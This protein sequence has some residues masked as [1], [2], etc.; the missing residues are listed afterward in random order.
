[1][2]NAKFI[3]LFQ[4]ADR[5]AQST[6][7]VCGELAG[8]LIT[9]RKD[10]EKDADAYKRLMKL[11]KDAISAKRVALKHERNVWGYISRHLLA[12]LVPDQI[13]EIDKATGRGKNRKVE[14]QYLKASEL[15]TAADVATAAKQI[16]DAVGLADQRATT[17]PKAKKVSTGLD[18]GESVR[19]MLR[20]NIKA[21][22]DILKAE[23]YKLLKA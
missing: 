23:G 7:A 21:L 13:V 4:K 22:R 11:G 18:V 15:S 17:K 6:F 9:E 10:G 8:M 19:N 12:Q 5:A 20:D 16:R 2:D 1:M 14:K 3:S